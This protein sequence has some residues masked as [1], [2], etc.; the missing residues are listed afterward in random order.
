M[1]TN[2][3][4]HLS[5]TNEYQSPICPLD[6][7]TLYILFWETRRMIGMNVFNNWAEVG[8]HKPVTICGLWF[9][10]LFDLPQLNTQEP[11]HVPRPPNIGHAAESHFLP[12]QVDESCT[13][14]QCSINS[15]YDTC[16]D[17]INRVQHER[18]L[19][20]TPHRFRFTTAYS[21]IVNILNIRAM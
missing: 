17:V 5:H 13:L 21:G 11:W 10:P 4:Q 3:F 14:E 19:H 6:I 7:V 18:F 9:W 8:I 16:N 2:A 12:H 1:T 20:W 15:Q